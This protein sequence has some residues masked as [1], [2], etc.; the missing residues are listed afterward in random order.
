MGTNYYVKFP[1]NPGTMKR[2][3]NNLDWEAKK[4][5]VLA[6]NDNYIEE[7]ENG[8]V[9]HNTYYCDL[10][11]LEQDYEIVLHLGKKSYGWHFSMCIYKEFDIYNIEDWKKFIIHKN[12]K[13]Y[14]EN[15]NVIS[16]EEFFDNI[17]N[18]LENIN[19]NEK[20]ILRNTNII[21]STNYNNYDELLN[22]NS[23]KRG[24]NGLW[25]HTYFVDHMDEK[26]PIDYTYH[27]DFF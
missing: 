19:D 17:E 6:S 14:D 5:S 21:S 13:I 11:S 22:A 24:K 3:Y 15:D 12:Y 10:F 9:Y 18:Q 2:K 23:A 16:F 25:S 26:Y 20:D 7:L 27:W 4:R 1:A 8:W